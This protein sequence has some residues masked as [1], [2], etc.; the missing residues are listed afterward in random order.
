MVDK[1]IVTNLSALEAKYGSAGLKDIECATQALIAA[2]KSRGLETR[3]VALDDAAIMKQIQ[4]ARVAEPGDPRENKD[5][6]DAVYRAFNPHYLMILGAIDVVPHQDMKNLLFT[7]H[8][9]GDRDEFAYGD[10]PYACD[11]PYSQNALDFTGPTRVVGRLP[12]LTGPSSRPAY[13]LRLLKTATGWKASPREKYETYFGISAEVWRDSTALSLRNIFG[14]DSDLR[15]CPAESCLWPASLINRRMHFI[16]CHGE[17]GDPQFYGES[18]TNPKDTP[19]SYTAEYIA[20]KGNIVEGTVVAAECC[21]GGQLYEIT[22][23]TP[24]GICSTYLAKRAYGFFGSTTIAYGPARGNAQA[25]LICQYFLRFVLAGASLGRAALE[26]RQ[27][28]VRRASFEEY[29]TDIK[30]LAQFNLYGDPSIVPV[31]EETSLMAVGP[32]VETV[33][34]SRKA[35][36]MEYVQKAGAVERAGR[37]EKL[38]DEGLLLAK[39]RPLVKPGYGESS[40][41]VKASLHD[42]ARK[43]NITPIE[44]LT[45]EVQ[46][47]PTSSDALPPHTPASDGRGNGG[48]KAKG[49]STSA[50]HVCFGIKGASATK[51]KTKRA[52]GAAAAGTAVTETSQSTGAATGPEPKRAFASYV[53]LEAKEVEGRIVSVREAYAK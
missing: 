5:A 37:R 53:V 2:D 31:A 14:S 45:F 12:D 47:A 30:T 3:L 22:P 10:L 41:A 29:P 23:V 38:H 51:V 13:L 36:S 17:I 28:F 6:I 27:R 46:T 7:R 32:R 49:L 39:S 43:L 9:G 11:A 48:A 26:A 8:E 1:V 42:I 21:Y 15:T 24:R 33:T 4:A 40:D 34:A 20:K 16:N 19:V 52:V 50:F 25:D 35:M 44:T 18:S